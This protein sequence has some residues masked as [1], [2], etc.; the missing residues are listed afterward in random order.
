[1]KENSGNYSVIDFSVNSAG[2]NDR[3]P[4][5]TSLSAG[6]YL[7]AVSAALGSSGYTLT[8][9]PPDSTLFSV[10]FDGSLTA[11]SGEAPFSPFRAVYSIGIAS[12]ALTLVTQSSLS[13]KKANILNPI[14]GAI[15]LWIKP[16]WNGNDNNNHQILRFGDSGGI[17]ITKDN[18]NALRLT[19]NRYGAKGGAEISVNTDVSGWKSGDWH[20]LVFTWSNSKKVIEIYVDSQIKARHSFNQTLPDILSD[21]LFLGGDRQSGYLYSVIDEL[22][23]YNKVLSEKEVINRYSNP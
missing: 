16:Y 21:E 12:P 15:E 4:A 11:V 20:H 5:R 9:R 14:D 13:Y 1:L 19:L 2:M 6:R 23:V 8:V 17:H 22:N 7:I 3:I 18:A 10:P